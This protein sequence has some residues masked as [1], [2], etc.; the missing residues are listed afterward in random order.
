MK[1]YQVTFTVN[2]KRVQQNVATTSYSD[3]KKIVLAQYNGSKVA[4]VNC[5]DLTTGYLG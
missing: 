3:A 4:I 2:G 1:Q 5:K